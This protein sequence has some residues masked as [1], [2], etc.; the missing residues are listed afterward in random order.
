MFDAA[1]ARHT[2]LMLPLAFQ[3]FLVRFVALAAL[4][5]VI[6]G[7]IRALASNF[8]T[9]HLAHSVILAVAFGLLVGAGLAYA[10]QTLHNTLLVAVAGLDTSQRSQVIAAVNRGV[11]PSDPAVRTAAI[12]C[13]SAFLRVR[14]AA[15]LRR[16]ERQSWIATGLAV[17]ACIGLGLTHGRLYYLGVALL[18]VVALPLTSLRQRR[19]ERNVAR[20]SQGLA[21]E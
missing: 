5:T 12:R 13:G 9:H 21:L 11:I 10:Q 20:L 15:E 2:L 8:S 1:S 3:P 4:G 6:F 16:N 18:L 17:V 7:L 14:S 19:I